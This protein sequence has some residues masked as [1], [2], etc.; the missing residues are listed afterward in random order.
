MRVWG[1][2]VTLSI[3]ALKSRLH[4]TMLFSRIPVPAAIGLAETLAPGVTP[5]D[6][7]DDTGIVDHYIND[8]HQERSTSLT[9]THL[10]CKRST[11]S[12]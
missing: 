11:H 3:Y 2:L 10:P 9:V 7:R 1:V 12:S 4:M 8:Q 6:A 5:G